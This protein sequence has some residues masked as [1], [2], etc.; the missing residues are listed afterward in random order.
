MRGIYT[1][2]LLLGAVLLAINVYGLT[3]S[4]RPEGL[5]PEVLRFS[6]NDLTL[7]KDAFIA[8]SSRISTETDFQYAT[9]LTHVISNGMAHV[10]WERFNP[11]QYNQ[12]I[13]IW[14]NY[15][16]YL[17]GKFSGIPE[18]ERYHFT[19]P[20]KSMERGVGL[21]GDASMLLSELLMREDIHN[22]IVTVPGHV[23]VEALLDGREVLLDP[24][25]GVVLDYDV[26]TYI[27]NADELEKE[28]NQKGF[29][30]NGEDVVKNG[31]KTGDVLYWDGSRHFVQKKYYFERVSYVLIWLLPILICA[32]SLILL[33]IKH[34]KKDD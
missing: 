19:I 9:R 27:Q 25:F 21:C 34:K 31:M 7:S 28:Y 13:P 4:L 22:S 16:L 12:T 23:M 14:E 1:V 8:S 20:E 30:G 2:T 29:I 6:Q 33:N 15:I 17:M 26:S 32:T 11:S 3:K 10:H 5:T 18:F 24:D